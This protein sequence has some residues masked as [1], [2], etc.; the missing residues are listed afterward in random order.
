MY[1]D[2][3]VEPLQEPPALILLA[4]DGYANSFRTDQD[5]L[6]VGSDMLEMIRRDGWQYVKNRL[7]GWLA[8]ASQLGSGDDI[9]VGLMYQHNA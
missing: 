5:F 2:V 3:R 1:T 8:E 4:T 7:N 6:K 9:T